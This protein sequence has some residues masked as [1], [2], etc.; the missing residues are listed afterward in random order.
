MGRGGGFDACRG[1]ETVNSRSEGVILLLS[2][3][4]T[5]DK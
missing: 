1:K 4:S 3:E 5:D 2:I